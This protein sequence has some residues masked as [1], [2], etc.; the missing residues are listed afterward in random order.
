MFPPTA[1]GFDIFGACNDV[2]YAGSKV[3]QAVYPLKY[4][5]EKRL[6]INK[7]EE[8]DIVVPSVSTSSA[9]VSGVGLFMSALNSGRELLRKKYLLDDI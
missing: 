1:P 5:E 9:G 6:A 7:A 2:V 8:L 3:G 4:G